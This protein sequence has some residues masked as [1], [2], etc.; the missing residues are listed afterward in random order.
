MHPIKV[1]MMLENYREYSARCEYL[2]MQIGETER[3]IEE[4]KGQIVEDSV[5]ITPVLNGMPHGQQGMGDPTGVLGGR[6]AEGYKTD[7]I[8]EAE[9]EL[10]RMKVEYY[11]KLP[12]VMFVNAWIKALSNKEL[13]VIENKTFGGVSWR[14]LA[15]MFHRE[16]GD[17]YSQDGMRRIRKQAMEKIYKVAE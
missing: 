17:M 16:F 13:F 7:H 4:M 14:Q 15:F 2:E 9:E 1:D 11:A 12:T 8:R 3:L 5:K 6:L 10:E